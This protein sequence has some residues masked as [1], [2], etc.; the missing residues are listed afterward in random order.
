MSDIAWC[1]DHDNYQKIAI[2]SGEDKNPVIKIYDLRISN[3]LPLATLQGH[4]EGI[5]SLY[6]TFIS[7]LL[8]LF[9]L[10][11]FRYFINIMVSQ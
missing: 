11:Y 7:F 8:T 2:A 10:F 1:P 6:F 3:S 9:Y 5:I 4:S